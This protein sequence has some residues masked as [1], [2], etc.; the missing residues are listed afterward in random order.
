MGLGKGNN[1]CSS[2]SGKTPRRRPKP[3]GDGCKP[4]DLDNP[5]G[6]EAEGDYFGGTFVLVESH[7]DDDTLLLWQLYEREMRSS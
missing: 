2:V 1:T 3:S 7:R 5:W 6:G 4:V